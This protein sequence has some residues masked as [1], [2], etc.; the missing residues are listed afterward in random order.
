MKRGPLGAM[1]LAADIIGAAGRSVAGH[2]A[3]ALFSLVAAFGIWVAIQDVDNPRVTGLAPAD[4]G[5]QVEV[6]NLP[7][8]F[9]V[10]DLQQVTVIVEARKGDLESLRPSD[11]RA[12]VD[13]KT[14]SPDVQAEGSRPVRVESR[15][16]GV[17]VLEVRPAT[18]PVKLIKAAERQV[19]VTVRQ[20]TPPPSGFSA[21]DLPAVLEPAI[22]T[23]RGR[24][25][26]VDSVATVDLDAN[27][28]T[29]RDETVS[30]EGELVARTAQGN[31]VTVVLSQR[32][33]RATFKITQLFSLRSIGVLPVI[34]G[35]PDR[36]YYIANVVIDPPI[37]QIT[38]PKSILDGLK[39]PLSLEALDVTGAQRTITLPKSVK[40]PP[41]VSTDR[42][43][44]V[45]R[46][47]IQPLEC[48]ATTG[49]CQ[50]VLFVLA[51][52][53]EGLA[54]G[55]VVEPG[56]YSVQVRISGPL[57]QLATLRTSDLRATISF[58]GAT[59][60]T[61]SYTAR[62]TAPAGVRVESVE[63]NVVTLRPAAGVTVP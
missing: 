52:L 47:E 40:S 3:L 61:A 11:F 45:V 39:D 21:D 33:A 9:I 56:S 48:A 26:Q 12:S 49:A 13:V 55:L 54:A 22:V 51:P 46:V 37:V 15:R 31:P 50:A 14:D 42:Q 34:T 16:K 27:L 43:T 29:A 19:P 17:E 36:G 18:V 1:H 6:F 2:W 8:G 24:Q 25:E 4:G 7:D 28:G 57:P 53:F 58:A 23:V 20:T 60:G 35:T 63:P 62:V 30:V 44:V 59:A 41:N 10:E 32:R 38:G 5:I